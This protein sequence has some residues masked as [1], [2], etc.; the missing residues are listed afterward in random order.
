MIDQPVRELGRTGFGHGDAPAQDEI[1]GGDVLDGPFRAARFRQGVHLHR[2]PRLPAP[3]GPSEPATKRIPT[4][5][6]RAGR[7][8]DVHLH[9]RARSRQVLLQQPEATG[10]PLGLK[11]CR[12]RLAA[13]QPSQFGTRHPGLAGFVPSDRF[14]SGGVPVRLQS[15][16][17][18]SGLAVRPDRIL[19]LPSVHPVRMWPAADPGDRQTVMATAQHVLHS[20]HVGSRHRRPLSQIQNRETVE[21]SGG[22]RRRK[23]AVATGQQEVRSGGKCP[24]KLRRRSNAV[25]VMF[26]YCRDLHTIDFNRPACHFPADAG[27]SRAC[28]CSAPL[29][30]CKCCSRHGYCWDCRV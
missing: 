25:G 30:A 19:K 12:L 20:L 3:L 29:R 24:A 18:G 5:S 2:I 26:M 21:G 9:R 6:V 14:D 10:V 22:S 28:R 11:S 13:T 23:S 17:V 4:V 7:I 15:T 8:G 16:P 27:F 1:N